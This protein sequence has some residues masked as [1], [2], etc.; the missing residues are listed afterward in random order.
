LE[1]NLVSILIPVYNRK[2][3]LAETVRSALAQT[4]N[5][6]E[7][8]IVD[9]CSTDGTWELVKKLAA[10]NSNIVIFQNK[11]NIGPVKNWKKCVEHANGDYSKILFSDDLISEN[12]IEDSLKSFDLETAFVLSEIVTF[13]QVREISLAKTSNGRQRDKQF[14]TDY[15]IKD[16]ILDN[17][18]GFPISPGC[19]LFRTIDLKNN[20][21]IEIN[22]PFNIEFS[23]LGAGNDLL[24]MLLTAHSYKNLIINK[25]IISYFRSH[26]NS[27]TLSN[28]IL[29]HYEY[30]KYFFL[31][32]HRA[33]LLSK[34]KSKLLINSLS[35]NEQKIIIPLIN[36][37]FSYKYLLT[38]F[39]HRLVIKL[40]N[41]LKKK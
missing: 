9:N 6:I 5:N 26:A 36:T 41:A 22:N 11:E 23:K 34:F 19:A 32:K 35:N 28:N 2:D 27:I 13:N 29:I 20:L 38:Y 14:L 31:I 18:Y 39:I 24:I 40:E 8:V 7:I 30:T 12:Y 3:L 25:N 17:K 1:K 16:I 33:D 4:Y 37:S 10:A 15:Y 21:M